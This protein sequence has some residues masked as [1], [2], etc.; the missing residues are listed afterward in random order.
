MLE[1]RPQ[2][3]LF[4]NALNA[5]WR[6]HTWIFVSQQF[7]FVPNGEAHNTVR[8]KEREQLFRPRPLSL[9]VGFVTRDG[10]A[11][12]NPPAVGHQEIF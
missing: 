2:A 10:H 12:E 6:D 4:P 3:T 9:I 7:Q 5:L 8:A 11:H 1:A